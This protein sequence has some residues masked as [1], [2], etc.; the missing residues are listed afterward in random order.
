MQPLSVIRD[1]NPALLKM[2]APAGFQIH[3]PK[4]SATATQAALESVPA[5]N[6]TAWRLHHVETGD[7]LEAIAKTY[8][9]PANRITA[10]NQLSSSLDKGNTLLIPAVYH[11]EVRPSRSSKFRN[12]RT[13]NSGMA[14]TVRKASATRHGTHI[15]ASRR[16]SAPI[17]VRRNGI[18]STAFAH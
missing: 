7:T 6:R 18:H 10:V 3:I 1:L 4:G 13:R 2:V 15:S 12:F 11:E 17:M 9:L 16:I 5:E 8:H 14:V